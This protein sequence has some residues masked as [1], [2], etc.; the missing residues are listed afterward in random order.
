[1][2]KILSVYNQY[3]KMY[4]SMNVTISCIY[5]IGIFNLLKTAV[6]V[7]MLIETIRI[8]IEKMSN[9][10]VPM[11]E[12][13]NILIIS[14]SINNFQSVKPK[15]QAKLTYLHQMFES[16][17]AMNEWISSIYPFTID[18]TYYE[19]LNMQQSSN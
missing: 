17:I 15:P 9:K 1:M 7:T 2:Y 6:Y 8:F 14:M 16:T 10:M 11:R 18:T 19:Q 4:K 3:Q 5:F 12:Y 13:M